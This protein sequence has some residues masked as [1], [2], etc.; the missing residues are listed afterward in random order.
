MAH[1]FKYKRTGDGLVG[2][3]KKDV[4][5]EKTVKTELGECEG[6]AVDLLQKKKIL[7]Y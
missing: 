2:R 5:G 7:R 6:V 3:I 4:R 1:F